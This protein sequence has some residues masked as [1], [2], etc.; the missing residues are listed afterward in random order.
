MNIW[1]LSVKIL[2]VLVFIAVVTLA[3]GRE[4]M[5]SAFAENPTQNFVNGRTSAES[6]NDAIKKTIAEKEI[7]SV[8]SGKNGDLPFLCKG[9]NYNYREDLNGVWVESSN[10]R[11]YYSF[12]ENMCVYYEYVCVPK[13]GVYSNRECE[14][15]A[16]RAVYNAMSSQ[17]G[18]VVTE[19]KLIGE[20]DNVFYYALETSATGNMKIIVHIRADT[21]KVVL[22]DARR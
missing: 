20:G 8:I 10:Q 2:S 7:L 6:Q 17:K 12:V 11:L 19:T 4:M 15:A 22:Y 5:I 1:N 13:T 16:R 14:K 18:V 9:I 21:K 3:I